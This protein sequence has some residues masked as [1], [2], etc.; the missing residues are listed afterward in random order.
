MFERRAKDLPT[1]LD[2]TSCF[3]K[4]K[5]V[6]RFFDLFF[7]KPKHAAA[8][9]GNPPSRTGQAGVLARPSTSWNWFPSGRWCVCA[10]ASIIYRRGGAAVHLRSARQLS[11]SLS[12]FLAF[13][14]M[15]C[16]PERVC[17]GFILPITRRTGASW[18]IE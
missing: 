1:P 2:D 7:V 12:P 16:E 14:G 11:C 6:L 5:A 18:E 3:E 13:S 15:F 4:N 9:S 17:A 10:L 8:F